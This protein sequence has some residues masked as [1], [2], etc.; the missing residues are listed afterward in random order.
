MPRQAAG[1][2][3]DACKR[4]RHVAGESLQLVDVLAVRVVQ[5]RAGGKEGHDLHDGVRDEVQ[6]SRGEGIA[7]MST[8]AKR[9]YDRF[10]IVE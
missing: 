5:H 6:E 8:A 9:M 2:G 10:E 1:R 4:H 7:V 3:D